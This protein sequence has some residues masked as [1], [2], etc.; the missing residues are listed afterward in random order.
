MT[1]GGTDGVMR[2]LMAAARYFPFAGGTET[3][4]HEVGRRLVERG[5]VVSILTANP[6]G[7]LPEYEKIAGIDVIRVRSWPAGRDWHLAPGLKRA[8]TNLRPDIVHVQGYHTFF[9]PVAM[10]SAARSGIPFVL[11]FHSGGHSSPLRNSIRKI[12]A[13]ALGPLVRQA[14][15]CIA[16]SQF[17]VSHFASAM[18]VPAERFRVLPNGANLKAELTNGDRSEDE[19]L[20]LS[21]GR[22]E[23]YKGHH[24]AIDAMPRLLRLRPDVRLQIVGSGPYEPALRARIARRGLADRVSIRSIP[25]SNRGDMAALMAEARLF[26]LFSNY[27]AHPVA[28]LEALSLNKTVVVTSTSGLKEI[29]DRGLARAVPL[30]AR[31]AVIAAAM[32]EAISAQKPA[33]AVKLTTWDEC[34]AELEAV[35]RRVLAERSTYAPM[36]LSCEAR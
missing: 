36:S 26:V 20:I 14:E 5:H 10:W 1:M 32:H 29:A 9:A 15:L 11:S 34:A 35:Y 17:E 13:A 25:P 3:H 19:N 27:E 21:V 7:Q 24:R 23:R 28:V 18:G 30:D 8:M 33:A 31:A 12:Q 2:I 6:G 22:L 16:V 4:I